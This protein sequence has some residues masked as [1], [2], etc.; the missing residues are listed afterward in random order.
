MAGV[1]VDPAQPG[2]P[3]RLPSLMAALM[4]AVSSATGLQSQ[5]TRFSPRGSASLP[6]S[7]IAPHIFTFLKTS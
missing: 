2:P 7:P 4:A 1:V 3:Q 6:P 5:P